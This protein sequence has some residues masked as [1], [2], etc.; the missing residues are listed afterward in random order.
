[1]SSQQENTNSSHHKKTKRVSPTECEI[2]EPKEDE[3]D[4]V[5]DKL[6]KIGCL[7]KHYQVQDCY[8]DTKGL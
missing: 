4:P 7:E 3:V 2:Y 1:M 8:F 5:I 6:T